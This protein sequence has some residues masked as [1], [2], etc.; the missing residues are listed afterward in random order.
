MK[1]L[2]G[3]DH[4]RANRMHR[5]NIEF[6]P[7]HTITLVTNHKPAADANDEALWRRLRVIGFD[8]VVPEDRRDAQL[9]NKL[10]GEDLTAVLAWCWRGW[11]D[12][13]RTGLSAP[14]AVTRRT[15]EYRA[16]G[17]SLGE[18]LAEQCITHQ[19]ARIGAGKC[20]GRGRRGRWL[21]TC[22]P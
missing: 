16:E 17:D 13:R 1:R 18:F 3:G 14:T 4:I 2:T 8:V 10:R 19:Y 15:D 11:W 22:R 12:Y 9:G 5:D 7:S 21:T 6:R 20:S